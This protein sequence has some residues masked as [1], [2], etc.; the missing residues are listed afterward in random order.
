MLRSFRTRV[1]REGWILLALLAVLFSAAI[2]RDINLLV[3]LCGMLLGMQLLNWRWAVSNLRSLEV[4]R[5]LPPTAI[6]GEPFEVELHM[7]NPRRRSGAWMITLTDT[8]SLDDSVTQR[9]KA[10]ILFAAVPPRDTQIERYRAC[11]GQRGTYRIGPAVASTSFPLGLVRRSAIAPAI[12]TL[13]VYPRVG[14]LTGQWRRRFQEADMGSRKA[15]RWQGLTAGDFHGLRDW[16]S[17]DSR[18]LIHWRTS[19]KQQ[20]L[21]VRQFERHRNQELVLVL[22]LGPPVAASEAIELAVSF[23]ATLASESCRRGGN[24]LVVSIAA[25]QSRILRGPASP[26]FMHEVLELLAVSQPAAH[27]HLPD[28]LQQALEIARHDSNI[29]VISPR[30]LDLDDPRHLGS[31]WDNITGK[32]LRVRTMAVDVSAA[33]FSDF[34]TFSSS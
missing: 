12:D 24:Q 3:A 7:S 26:A 23:A 31:V 34:F 32:N 5:R 21:M 10:D 19:A 4:Q 8:A 9:L 6:A 11:L 1:T 17:G 30:P 28:Q 2:N 29:V 27:D 18:R 20:A 22:D 14:A 16:R 25:R 15:Q 13:I 33:N